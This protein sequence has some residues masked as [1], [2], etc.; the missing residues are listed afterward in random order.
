M[1]NKYNT[2]SGRFWAGFFD[3]IILLPFVLFDFIFLKPDK[4]LFI[5]IPWLLISYTMYFAYSILLHWKYGQTVGKRIMK[6]SV[7]DV[8]EEKGLSL[9]QALLRDSIPLFIQI[10]VLIK[11]V[12]V[13]I[14]IGHYSEIDIAHESVML[15]YVSLAWFIIEVVTMLTNKKRRALHDFIAKT[16]VINNNA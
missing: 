4:S 3:G 8:S 5:V 1:D 11:L 2:F 9:L 12:I 10:L 13:T 16:V 6:V 7:V 15:S 14:K